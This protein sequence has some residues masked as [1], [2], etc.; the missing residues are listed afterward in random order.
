MSSPVLDPAKQEHALESIEDEGEQ[1]D[2]NAGIEETGATVYILQNVEELLG[3]S[4]SAFKQ[5]SALQLADTT[6]TRRRLLK[7]ANSM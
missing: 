3:L 4:D 7:R 1:G 2:A 6:L 5:L